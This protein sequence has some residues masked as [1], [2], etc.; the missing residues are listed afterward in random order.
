MNDGTTSD[1]SMNFGG[2]GMKKFKIM[3][4]KKC[5]KIKKS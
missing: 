5:N 1:S 4:C 2:N 3:K